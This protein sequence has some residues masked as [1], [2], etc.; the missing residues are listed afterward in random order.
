MCLTVKTEVVSNFMEDK[1]LN[2]EHKTRQ[3][4]D[5]QNIEDNC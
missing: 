5:H 3:R 2:S 4:K 1:P